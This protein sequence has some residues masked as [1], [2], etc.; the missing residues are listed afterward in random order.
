MIMSTII[1]APTL[2]VIL[3]YVSSGPAAK[4]NI[5]DDVNEENK[6]PERENSAIV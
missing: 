1:T 2:R 4:L 6:R 5:S 3:V